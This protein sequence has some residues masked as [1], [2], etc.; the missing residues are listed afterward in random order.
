MNSL[1]YLFQDAQKKQQM[2]GCEGR[3][4]EAHP[5]CFIY[6]IFWL[7][8]S[9]YSLPIAL[10]LNLITDF[11]GVRKVRNSPFKTYI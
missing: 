11:T 10:P 5:K 8:Q 6:R 3:S 7:A 2:Q 1:I 4:P 9:L